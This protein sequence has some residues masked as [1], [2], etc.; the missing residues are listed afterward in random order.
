MKTELEEKLK[1][2]ECLLRGMSE[3]ERLSTL[4]IIRS[5]LH[6][7]SPFKDEPVDCVLWIKASKLKANEYNPNIMAQLNS[8]YY[9]LHY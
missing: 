7:L 9:T 8:A 5:R 4:N 3:D 1:S 2:I 6:E